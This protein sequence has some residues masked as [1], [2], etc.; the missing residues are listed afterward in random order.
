MKLISSKKLLDTPIFS[1]TQDHAY[2]P[3]GFEIKRAIV[4]HGGSA[5]MMPLDD[6]KRI[7]LVRQYRLPARQ[8][9]WEL[10]AGRVDKGENVLQA[11]KRELKEETGLKA[12]T[13]TRLTSFFVSPG[14]LEEKMTIYLAEGLTN[15][16]QEPM[17]DERIELRWFAT[18]ELDEMIRAGRIIDAK[19]IIGFLTWKRY[20]AA[21]K[22][23][24]SSKRS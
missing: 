17:E 22:A 20:G 10:P 4:K 15:G 5:V 9:L 3:D 8:M 23:G 7:L 24:K 21:T 2:D 13:W 6:K 19:T 1:V 12:K 11:A 16:E 18:R 14:F